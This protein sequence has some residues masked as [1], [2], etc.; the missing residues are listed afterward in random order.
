MTAAPEP[1]VA[2]VHDYLAHA[3]EQFNYDQ[4]LHTFLDIERFR[5]WAGVVDAHR[6][7][8]GARFLSS[9][10]GFAGSVA[11]YA[12]A[13]AAPAIGVEVDADYVRMGRLR[14]ADT[15]KAEVLAYDGTTLPFPSGA[16]DIVESMDV[17]EHTADPRGYLAELGRVLAPGGVILLV[18]PNRLWPLEQHLGIAGPPWLPVPAADRLFGLLAR[19]P[20]L[21]DD[22]R[23]KY[24]RLAGMRTQ[25]LSLLRLRRLAGS[26]GLRLTLLR[27]RDHDDWPLPP[28]PAWAEALLDHR[29][30][31]YVSPVPTL[32]VVLRRS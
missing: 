5:R 3:R 1:F 15:R 27:A 16:F 32:P 21:D 17:I 31:R 26:L 18:T 14:V 12:E 10:C 9:G 2:A 22:R 11:A 23:F 30:T 29:G 25:N 13:G 8:A 19:L 28:A 7:V 4:L 6:S 20:R 24:Q